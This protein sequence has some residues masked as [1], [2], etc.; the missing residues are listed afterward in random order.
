VFGSKNGWE[1]ASYLRTGAGPGT[2]PYP[3]TLGKPAWL[4]DLVREQQ[5]TRRAVALY[6]QTS[7]GKILLQGAD[8]LALVQRLCANE[9]DVAPGRMVYT[10]MLNERGGYESDVTVTRLGADRFLVVTGSAQTPRDLDWIARHTR[11]GEHAV[12]VDVSGM[13]AVL[14]LMGP[15]ARTLLGRVGARTT[16]EELGPEQ[17]KFATT[18]EIDLGFARVRAARMSYVG[19]P[20]YE[21]YVPTEMTRHVYLALHA[22]SE[23]LGADG[24]GLAD[25]G[26]YALD[27]LRI[28]A[29]RRAWGAEL[30]PDETP[31]EAG[32]TAFVKLHKAN[33]FIGRAAL[34]HLPG[35]RLRKKLVTVVADAADAYLW[36]GEALRIGG[37]AAG[38]VT[39]AGWSDA[40]GRCVALAYVRGAHAATA[41]AG[42]PVSVDVW[43]EAVPGTAWDHWTAR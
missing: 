24:G 43:G 32:A 11:A 7:F 38:E 35:E 16:F 14:S 26:Y 13:T 10:P 22:A 42:T 21:L 39:S 15:N 3:H 12:A 18:R 29:G 34:E 23:G 20:G 30:G 25:A 9:M 8:A 4:G 2:P 6:D 33:G 17:L 41:F 28:E 27:A 5:A 40:A 37:E 19:G 1:R 31:L 36:G